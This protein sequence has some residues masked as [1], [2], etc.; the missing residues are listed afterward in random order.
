LNPL[1]S[2][3]IP[4]FNRT[5]FLLKALRAFEAQSFRNFEICISDG[6]STDG[7]SQ[8]IISYL[9]SSGL[10]SRYQLQEQQ[11]RYDPNIRA[12]IA[13]ATGKYCF[14]LGNDDCPADT[15]ALERLAALLEQY[16]WP[17][18]VITNYHE[19]SS[20]VTFRRVNT[21]GTLGCG[22]SI[23]ASAFR[24]FSFVSG[25]L[26]DR[27][28]AQRFATHKWDGSEMYQTF[29]GCRIIATGGQLLGISDVLIHKDIQLTD[30]QA[31]SY[32][33]RPR[34]WPCPVIERPLP[35]AQLG[36]VAFDGI[37]PSVRERD[38]NRFVR[39]IFT[40]LVLFTYPPWLIEYRRVQSWRY[41]LGVAL[42]MRPRNLL[43][44]VPANWFTRL[45]VSALF[46][47]VTIAG[48]LIPRVVFEK[49]KPALY[50]RA[51]AWRH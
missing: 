24:N 18:V 23:A 22:P 47:C 42:G 48:L 21:T 49:L 19:L 12:A 7:R 13:L 16:S 15:H 34:V 37:R 31:D 5:S 10:P 11:S 51:K 20:G 3:C 26:L 46:A 9:Q 33:K 41:A 45:Y 25:I 28:Q 30:E 2:I 38:L 17:Q 27:E 39:L 1:F 36:R 32:A 43:K 40:Q 50:R 35:L 4:Q 6:R 8:E 14:L 44:D 29:L